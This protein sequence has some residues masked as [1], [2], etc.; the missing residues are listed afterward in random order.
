MQ[1]VEPILMIE[2]PLEIVLAVERGTHRAREARER[3]EA[4]VVELPAAA[5]GAARA[6]GV[7]SLGRQGNPLAG[8]GEACAG[9][10]IDGKD[11]R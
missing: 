1:E 4:R 10:E 6:A 8:L 5:L 3:G 11:C 9:P 2:G 7:G